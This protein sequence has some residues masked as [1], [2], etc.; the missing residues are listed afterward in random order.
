[1][2]DRQYWQQARHQQVYREEFQLI[3]YASQ[4]PMIH[5]GATPHIAARMAFIPAAE[6]GRLKE[7]SS[8]QPAGLLQVSDQVDPD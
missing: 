7:L 4:V 3:G 1:M 5:N 2:L 6:H 8:G